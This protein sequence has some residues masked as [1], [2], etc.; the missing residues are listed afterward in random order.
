MV[1]EDLGG[2]TRRVG[3][4]TRRLESRLNVLEAGLYVLEAGLGV[5][6][7]RLGVMEAGL[8]CKNH[9]FGTPCILVRFC[10]G[11]ERATDAGRNFKTP[12]PP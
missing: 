2:R 8:S 7:A 3:G 9:S 5:L 4:Q 12:F 10:V 11:P 6:E 1:F